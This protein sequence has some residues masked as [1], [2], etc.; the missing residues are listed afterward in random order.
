MPSLGDGSFSPFSRNF[1][2]VRDANTRHAQLALSD[3]LAG[4]HGALGASPGSYRARV[5]ALFASHLVKPPS[6]PLIA[7]G[8]F[9]GVPIALVPAIDAD[10]D[11]V[12]APESARTSPN[13]RDDSAGKPLNQ[14]ASRL[15]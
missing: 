13:A 3:D 4:R 1:L 7:G 5:R 14:P 10:G 6:A 8:P 11:H 2:V 9:T 15:E 12:M